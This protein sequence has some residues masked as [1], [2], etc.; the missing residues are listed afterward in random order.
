MTIVTGTFFVP[1]AGEAPVFARGYVRWSPTAAGNL[2]D[3]VFLPLPFRVALVN[4]VMTVDLSA[5]GPGWVWAVTY[6]FYG[7]VQRTRYYL[8]PSSS[9]P[10]D[11]RDL[12]EVDPRTT[13]PTIEPDAGWYAY[14]QLL[15]AKQVGV[16]HVVT[17]NEPREDFGTVVWIGGTTQPV[18]MAELTDI[19]FK[20]AA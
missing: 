20:P 19:W 1:D 12:V 11:I 9:V 13:D 2:P 16:V 5:T 6:Q 3:G 18:N 17:G 4:G 8:V 15:A 14:L 7:L 10:I